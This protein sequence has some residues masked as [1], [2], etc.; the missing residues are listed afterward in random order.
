[1]EEKA[2]KDSMITPTGNTVYTTTRSSA[3]GKAKMKIRFK[4]VGFSFAVFLSL[5][6]SCTPDEFDDPIPIIFFQPIEINIALPQYANLNTLGYV[7]IDD[8][9]G[10][11]GIILHKKNP[12][13]YLA[14]ERNCSFQP[15]QACATV[16][17][18]TS[19]LF[20]QDACC[21]S[22]FNWDGVPTAGVA[23]RPLRQYKTSLN[24]TLL[25]IT[26]EIIN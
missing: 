21:G 3:T 25:T 13:T 8:N 24:G 6:L 12:F 2:E 22:M 7:Y 4:L 18:H 5:V 11:R 15:N 17:V 10:V 9:A 14:I 26:D 23:W 16:E 20:L 19:T 1:M